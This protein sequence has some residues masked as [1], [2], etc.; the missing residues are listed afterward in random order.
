M[1]ID[2]HFRRITFLDA[3][4]QK[5][6]VMA[7]VIFRDMRTR[8]FNHGLGFLVVSLWPLSHMVIIIF[9]YQLAGRTSPFGEDIRVFFAT[10]LIPTLAFN[11]ISRFM[12][13]SLILNRPMLAF[14][15]VTVVDIMFGRALLEI[16]AAFITLAFF[17]LIMLGLGDNPMPYNIEEALYA[18]LATLLLSV[19]VGT[20]AG[21]IVMFFQFFA[22]LYALLLILVYMGS[23]ILFV[24]A[25]LPAPLQYLL[26][27]NP[28]LQC[29]E[30]MRVAYYPTYSDKLL[31]KT[32]VIAYGI[33]ALFL[34]LLLERLLRW[35]ILEG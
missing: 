20:L 10:G 34:G 24:A 12:S 30:W 21:V 27:W 17:F 35:K 31:D 29:V 8:F 32:Y 1:T 5:R 9:I 22:T 3:L 11:Y 25:A 15:A 6:N 26:S 4:R 28:V 2:Y 33:I 7:A 18:Y 19:G 16:V 23:G 14:P 13:L